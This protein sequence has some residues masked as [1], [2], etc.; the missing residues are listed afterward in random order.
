MVHFYGSFQ[1][2]RLR[3]I[4]NA[5]KREENYEPSQLVITVCLKLLKHIVGYTTIDI[6]K[7]QNVK[8][9]NR[10]LLLVFFNLKRYRHI[11]FRIICT[12]FGD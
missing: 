3:H 5:I 10:S 2:A 8:L 12:F 6:S 11:S 4:D 7:S 9:T 1:K